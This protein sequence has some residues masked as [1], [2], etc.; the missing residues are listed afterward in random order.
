MCSPKEIINAYSTGGGQK[1]TAG[2][3]GESLPDILFAPDNFARNLV[4][5]FDILA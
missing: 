1:G 3:K 4:N 2:Q 5:R